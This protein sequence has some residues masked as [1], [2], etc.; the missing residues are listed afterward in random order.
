MSDVE[1]GSTTAGSEGSAGSAGADTQAGSTSAGA[2]QGVGAVSEAT[3]IAG[4]IAKHKGSSIDSGAQVGAIGAAAAKAAKAAE[5]V[6]TPMTPEQYQANYK[7]T[8]RGKEHE[9]PEMY[10]QLIKDATTEKEIRELHEKAMWFQ[11]S[12]PKLQETE[13][14]LSGLTKGLSVLDKHLQNKDYGKFFE[15]F[16]LTDDQLFD[17][18]RKR[19]EY[20]QMPPE[21]RQKMDAERELYDRTQQLEQQNATLQER[22]A[23]AQTQQKDTQLRGILQHPSISPIAT[24]H[25]GGQQGFYRDVAQHAWF[26]E[27]STGQDMTPEQAVLSYIQQRGLSAQQPANATQPGATAVSQQ[28]HMPQQRA[29]TLPTVPSQGTSP[30]KKVVSSMNDLR[31]ARA[32]AEAQHGG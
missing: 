8:F 4:K 30:A 13:S 25:P 21:Q 11:E 27:Q 12:K 24:V 15:A 5:G 1:S 31:A 17:Y 26:V 22:Y 10:R 29:P 9:I 6:N 2:E 14:Q 20:Q 32:R 18:A 28:A 7:F 19:L 16:G 23:E 3:A